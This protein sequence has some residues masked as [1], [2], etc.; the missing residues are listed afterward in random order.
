MTKIILS[1]LCALVFAWVPSTATSQSRYS[2]VA[3]GATNNP[4][5]LVVLTFDT[6]DVER[7]FPLAS[8]GALAAWTGTETRRP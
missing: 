1:A 5:D 4:N 2:T 7:S 6:S 3:I 8:T